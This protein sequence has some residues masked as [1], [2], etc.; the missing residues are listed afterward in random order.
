M[1]YKS[2]D[3]DSACIIEEL[4]SQCSWNFVSK[5]D[6]GIKWTKWTWR[7][8]QGSAL[9]GLVGHSQEQ[10]GDKKPL[11]RLKLGN[12]VIWLTQLNDYSCYCVGREQK[13]S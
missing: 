7:G 12:D 4:R 6:S 10:K 13:R 5:E 1:K 2:A 11:A 3:I 8:G 9:A